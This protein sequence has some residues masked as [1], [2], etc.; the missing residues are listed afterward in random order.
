MK[1]FSPRPS[2]PA[3]GGVLYLLPPRVWLAQR[4][5]NVFEDEPPAPWRAPDF[6]DLPQPGPPLDCETQYLQFLRQA[7]CRHQPCNTH[8]LPA[9]ITMSTSRD[10][11]D[12]RRK[13]C[14]G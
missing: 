13:P 7:F 6:R 9:F 10:Y 1:F 5:Q 8:G 2:K 4:R 11:S 3:R 14:I 12:A